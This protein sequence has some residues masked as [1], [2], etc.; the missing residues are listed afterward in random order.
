VIHIVVFQSLVVGGWADQKPREI[1]DQHIDNPAALAYA[2]GLPPP[3]MTK[4]ELPSTWRREGSARPGAS[5]AA[6]SRD[7]IVLAFRGGDYVQIGKI[8]IMQEGDKIHDRDP[9]NE[10]DFYKLGL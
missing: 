4:F 1:P 3:P 6:S 7:G 10:S 9:V 8:R 5:S 2:F